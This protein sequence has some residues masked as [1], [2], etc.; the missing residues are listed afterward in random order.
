MAS[1]LTESARCAIPSLKSAG[2]FAKVAPAAASLPMT[3]QGRIL[4]TLLTLIGR[5]PLRLNRALGALFGWLFLLLP[6]RTRNVARR[7]LELCFQDSG[8][9]QAL[10]RA[11][12]FN[13]GRGF[14]ELAWFWTRPREQVL[15]LVNQVHGLEHLTAGVESGNG[16]LLAAPHLGAWELLCQFLSTQGHCTFL[17]REPKD[18]GIEEV[19]TRG[20]ERLGADL[21]QA[22]GRGVRELFRALK[23]GNI[24][25]I[26]PDQQPKRGQGEFS[27]FFGIPA[28]TMVLF[29]KMASKTDAPLVF[30]FARRLPG[31]QG[32]D[33]HF[34]PGDETIRDKDLATSVAALNAQ[35]E[36]CVR[37]APEQYQWGYKRFSIRPEGEEKLY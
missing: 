22:G 26:L 23:K 17:Y 11:N 34:I 4:Q 9:Q 5:L 31:T 32:F 35:V 20:R 15:K 27:P 16:V 21:V 36:A 7:N 8:E 3:T 1:I 14:M 19:V 24:V 18:S 28:L 33:I 30:A 6:N 13:T 10:L 29:S 2:P 12:M 37:M 25:G